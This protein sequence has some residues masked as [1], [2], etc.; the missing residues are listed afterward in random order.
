VI[1]LIYTLITT[2][3]TIVCVTLYLHRGQAHRS[4]EFHPALAHFMR[5]WL[6]LTTGMIT[7]EWV[8]VHRKHHRYSDVE[9]DPHSPVVNS[10]VKILFGGVWYYRRAS[11][12]RAMVD[13]YGTGTPDDWIEQK[14]YTPHPWLGILLLLVIDILLFGPSGI[15][16]WGVQILWIPFWAAGVINGIAHAWGYRNGVTKDN[17]R[18]ISPWGIIVGGEELHGNHHLRPA[19]P[20]MSIK[21]WEFDI[22]WM[23]YRLFNLLGLA[24]TR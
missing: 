3:I 12:D 6:W 5:F 24:H 15:L 4:I 1:E 19:S 23:W 14:L 22:G 11:Q 13:A 2:H 18:N 7:K 10:V 17:S 21:P 20:K 16:V 9:G 8:A